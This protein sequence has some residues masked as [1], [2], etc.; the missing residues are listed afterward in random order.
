MLHLFAIMLPI[1]GVGLCLLIGRLGP[2]P[3]DSRHVQT[4]DSMKV[5]VSKMAPLR[6]SYVRR[7]GIWHR[8]KVMSHGSLTLKVDEPIRRS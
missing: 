7:G 1:A 8:R 6:H 4:T 5:Q 2:V 3:E